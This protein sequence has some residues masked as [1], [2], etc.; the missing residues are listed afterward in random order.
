MKLKLGIIGKTLK[1]TA[2][3]ALHAKI[4]RELGLMGSYDIVEM[5]P[6]AVPAELKRLQHEGY[7]GLNVT[8]PYKQTVIPYLTELSR[9]AR[10]IGAVNTIHFTK[11]GRALGYNTDYG[12][13]G[14]S[15]KS[16]HI[17]PQ[18]KIC[19]VLGTGGAAR[20]VI[21]NLADNHAGEIVSVS[22]TPNAK[23]DFNDFTHSVKAVQIDYEALAGRV[24]GDILINCTPVGMYPACDASPL[25]E[26]TVQGYKAVVDLIYNPRETLLLR[27]GREGGA[28][29]LNGM[30][31]LVA[32]AVAS[33]EI[34]QGRDISDDVTKKIAQEMEEYL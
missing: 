11:D 33:E 10:T 9:E 32:Q 28:T 7:D 34:W 1:H 23:P 29:V 31:M 19:V 13:F 22:R 16:A 26:A 2:S 25:P 14:R 6:E 3:P 8:I 15:L 20:A 24:Q 5:V 18:G 21:Q 12:G 4:F 27:Y 30:H 17:E